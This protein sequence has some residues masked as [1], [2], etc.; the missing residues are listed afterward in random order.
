M[1]IISVLALRTACL[2]MEILSK[3]RYMLSENENCN[4]SNNLSAEIL[5]DIVHFYSFPLWQRKNGNQEV[6]LWMRIKGTGTLLYTFLYLNDN[7]G[8]RDPYLRCQD[9]VWASQ[10]QSR[11]PGLL[12]TGSMGEIFPSTLG[13]VNIFWSLLNILLT[14]QDSSVYLKSY[15]HG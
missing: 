12:L 3:L 10:K 4:S 15:R 6:T 2:P 7:G 13:L 11:F 5:D 14:F 9:W 1:I 8:V